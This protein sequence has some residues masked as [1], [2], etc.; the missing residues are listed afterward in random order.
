MPTSKIGW[1][2][3]I[4]DSA[5][6]KFDVTIKD[7]LGRIQFQRRDCGTETDRFGELVNIPMK[8]GQEVGVTIENLKGAKKVQ[9]F[10]N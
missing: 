7:S 1:L 9:V 5:G 8:I 3:S 2:H 6:A 4:A 10:L